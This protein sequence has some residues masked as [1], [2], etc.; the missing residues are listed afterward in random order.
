LTID[1]TFITFITFITTSVN[2]K[3]GKGNVI[4]AMMQ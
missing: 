2:R 3:D 4:A 1:S